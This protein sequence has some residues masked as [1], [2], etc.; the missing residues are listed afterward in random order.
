MNEMWIECMLMLV[1]CSCDDAT[2]NLG[3]DVDE[4]LAM[5]GDAENVMPQESM[6]LMKG[7]VQVCSKIN[8]ARYLYLLIFVWRLRIHYDALIKT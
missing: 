1:L 3:V 6:M 4:F 5:A 2:L 7:L 8:H